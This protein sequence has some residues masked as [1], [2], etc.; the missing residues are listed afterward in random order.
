LNKKLSFLF[1]AMLCSIL[2]FD[3]FHTNQSDI[4]EIKPGITVKNENLKLSKNSFMTTYS[5]DEKAVCS[6]FGDQQSADICDDGAGGAIIV[7]ED[8]RGEYSDIYSQRIDVQGNPLWNEL[9]VAVCR[10]NYEQSNPVLCSDGSGGAIFTWRDRR[11]SYAHIYAQK[12]S[13]DGNL[14]W[15][16]FGVL[17][18]STDD[19]QQFPEISTDGSGG[20]F[21]T[22]YD[23]RGD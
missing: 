15:S 9:G 16:T 5:V 10:A 1:L 18:C 21:I 3:T 11:S 4:S 12:I 2:I 7:W 23:D 8:Y 20:A 13:S 22:W 19:Y 17:I 14:Q 6:Y